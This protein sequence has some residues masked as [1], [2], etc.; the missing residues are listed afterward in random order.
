MLDRLNQIWIQERVQL[1]L[2]P[3]EIIVTSADSGIL[4]PIVNAVSLHQ[5]SCW[6]PEVYLIKFTFF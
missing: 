1:W 6:R 4:E 3:Y 5:V 2:R